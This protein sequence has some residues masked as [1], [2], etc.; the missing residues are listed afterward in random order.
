MNYTAGIAGIAKS[1]AS[2]GLAD[3]TYDGTMS[4]LA[5]V[6]GS[7]V[8]YDPNDPDKGLTGSPNLPPEELEKWG[9]S[10]N[11]ELLGLINGMLHPI[12]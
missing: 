5:D 11:D 6:M 9:V 2:V 12:K 7:G 4:A 1:G 3:E 8:N 10:S